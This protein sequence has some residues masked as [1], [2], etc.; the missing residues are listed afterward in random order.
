L[1]FLAMYLAYSYRMR[2]LSR[3]FA[4]GLEERV[5]ERI[6]IARELH[7][8]LLQSFQALM[9]QF[10]AA[11][12][13]VPRRPDDAVHALDEAI[14]ATAQAIADGREAISDLR[15]DPVTQRDLP[16]LLNAT[17]QELGVASGA[18]KH[19]PTFRVI[20][21]GKPQPIPGNLLGEVYRIAREAIRNAFLHADASG[22]EAEVHYDR[23]RLRLRIRDDGR[24][25]DPKILAGGGRSG[26]WGIPG[27]RE[28]AQRIGSTVEFWTEAGAGT[29]VE[30]VLPAA[31]AYG[32]QRNGRRFR[33]FRR[34]GL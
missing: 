8:T 16:E 30:L 29:E 28:R 11:R 12:N 3:Q 7:D 25:I 6:R 13:M 34:A 4:A 33:L 24:G 32:K 22:I 14:A 27:I 17:G 15:P 19:L 21:E 18:N 1:A 10:Q 23:D 26:H 2:R 20:V 9:F 5:G 31:I